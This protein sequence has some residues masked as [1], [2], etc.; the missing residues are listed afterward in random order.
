MEIN[1]SINKLSL[2]DIA[3]SKLKDMILN[4]EFQPGD[5][6]TEFQVLASLGMSRTPIRQALHRLD[7]EG[8]VNL[9]PRKGWFVV[10]ISLADIQEVFVIREA[11]EGIAARQAAEIISDDTLQSLNNYMQEAGENTGSDMEHFEPGD[12]I[13]NVIFDIVK[14]QRMN[15]VISLY[16]DHLQRL[17][18]LA[19]RIPG[20]AQQSY[21]EHLAILEAL[22]LHD[23]DLA[24]RRMREHIQS[25]K[26]SVFGAIVDGRVSL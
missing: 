21:Q 18:N 24:E 5:P 2:S 9:I 12:K 1:S 13:H 20:R 26:K 10:G 6:I 17:H 25:S 23:G 19:I 3:Y 22:N 4:L 11:L 16:K 7:Q 8:F 15:R 14:N